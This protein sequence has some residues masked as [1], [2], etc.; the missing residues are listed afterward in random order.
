MP[1]K[2]WVF[3][4]SALSNFLLSDSAF[5]IEK[6]YSNRGIITGQVYDEISA[7]ILD[8]PK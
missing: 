7:G 1:E 5:I 3:D 2:K 6:R 4:T 8:Y